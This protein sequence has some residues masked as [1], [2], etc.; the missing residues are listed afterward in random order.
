M[1]V[2]HFEFYSNIKSIFANETHSKAN[3][4]TQSFNKVNASTSITQSSSMNS[5]SSKSVDR[6][7]KESFASVNNPEE[8]SDMMS[9]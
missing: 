8:N 3:Q 5:A 1:L 7:S 9:R 4:R 2:D 6:L